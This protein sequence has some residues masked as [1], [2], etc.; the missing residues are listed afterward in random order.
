MSPPLVASFSRNTFPASR[1]LVPNAFRTPAF[2]PTSHIC[3]FALEPA[4]ANVSGSSGEKATE[5]TLP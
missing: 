4:A 3:S 1:S 2:E 5:K